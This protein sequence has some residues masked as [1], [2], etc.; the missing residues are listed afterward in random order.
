MTD[1]SPPSGRYSVGAGVYN[2]AGIGPW[3]YIETRNGRYLHVWMRY[4]WLPWHRGFRC[5][6]RCRTGKRVIAWGK[7]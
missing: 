5:C 6:L 1:P 4:F 2:C 7:S 3:L